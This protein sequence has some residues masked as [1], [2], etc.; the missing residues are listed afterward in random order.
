MGILR[1][2]DCEVVWNGKKGEH[3]LDAPGNGSSFLDV[4]HLN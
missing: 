4:I 1:A 2:E 3:W